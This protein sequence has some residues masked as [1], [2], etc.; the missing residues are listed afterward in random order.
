MDLYT[1]VCKPRDNHA[2]VHHAAESCPQHLLANATDLLKPNELTVQLRL[3]STPAVTFSPLLASHI[4]V[5]PA[6]MR[7]NGLGLL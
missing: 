1:S 7:M 4:I 6:A 5:L 3:S 2:D